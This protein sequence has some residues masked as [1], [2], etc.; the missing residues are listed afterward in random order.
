MADPP[1][2]RDGESSMP[3]ERSAAGFGTLF[4]CPLSRSDGSQ[5]TTSDLLGTN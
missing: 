3:A 5:R 1:A 2:L 4:P